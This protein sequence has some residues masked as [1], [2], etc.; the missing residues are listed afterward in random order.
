MGYRVY[1]FSLIESGDLTKYCRNDSEFVV[2]I[3]GGDDNW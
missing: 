1:E 2:F 3:R